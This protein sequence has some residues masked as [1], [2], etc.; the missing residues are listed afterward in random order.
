MPPCIGSEVGLQE[1]KAGAVAP[2]VEPPAEHTT[3]IQAAKS[4]VKEYHEALGLHLGP[5]E[6]RVN[7]ALSTYY[8]EDC[9]WHGVAPFDVQTGGAAVAEVFWCPFLESFGKVQRRDDI[10]IAGEGTDCRAAETGTWVHTMG[11][12]VGLFDKPWL[13]IPPTGRLC[14]VRY[15]EFSCV[16]LERRQIIQAG[17]HVDVLSVMAQAGHYPLPPPTGVMLPFTPG[18]MTHDGIVTEPQDEAETAKT[19]QLL[20]EMIEALN[21][22]NIKKNLSS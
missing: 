11:H 20:E 17:F 18:P 15:C 3:Q 6:E 1:V 13:G 10:F 16:D 19:I 2:D 8:S 5:D 9:A 4:V 7:K 14:F 21:R 12:L 22:C